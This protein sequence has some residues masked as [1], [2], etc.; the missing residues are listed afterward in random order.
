M[1]QIIKLRKS[2]K[3][4]KKYMVTIDKKTIHFGAFGMSDFT[5]HKDNDR[6]LNYIKRHRKR[7]DWSKKGINSRGF[8]SRW[9]L[10]EKKTLSSAKKH[11]EKK[12]NVII[13]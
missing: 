12:F 7:E 5:K 13:K 1:S 6:R 4:E 3:P 8:W 2:N 9:L 10:W 11:I